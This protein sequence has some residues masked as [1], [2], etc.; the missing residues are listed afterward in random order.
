MQVYK[1]NVWVAK[2]ARYTKDKTNA[3]SNFN[4][5]KNLMNNKINHNFYKNLPNTLYKIIIINKRECLIPNESKKSNQTVSHN[6]IIH[7]VHVGANRQK[8]QTNAVVQPVIG[9][10]R[11][12]LHVTIFRC[13][14]KLLLCQS[15]FFMN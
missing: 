14:I 8:F 15:A 13:F 6:T 1:Q 7:F 11:L 9:W 5:Y 10:L 12:D 3:Y 2:V 4:D